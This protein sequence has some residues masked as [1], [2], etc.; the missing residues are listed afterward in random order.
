MH[1]L[2]VWGDEPALREYAGS[3]AESLAATVDYI[4]V[5]G[6]A[7][8]SPESLWEQINQHHITLLVTTAPSRTSLYDS[9]WVRALW[10][11]PCPMLFLPAAYAAGPPPTRCCVLADGEVLQPGW[12][13][14]AARALLQHWQLQ[15]TLVM[16]GATE[17]EMRYGRQHLLTQW[18][19]L[20]PAP[21]LGVE[22]LAAAPFSSLHD[23]ERWLA[24]QAPH[25]IVCVARRL[26]LPRVSWTR[27]AL[28]TLLTQATTPV[29]VVP[30]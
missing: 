12:A 30:E 10:E 14:A 26:N 18:S 8:P 3:L 7:A 11:A 21:Y 29:L 6:G 2:I 19:S 4:D 9:I 22:A 16:V 28:M 27:R 15:S 20:V 5:D 17:F 25:L 13:A 23:V 1:H 24:E